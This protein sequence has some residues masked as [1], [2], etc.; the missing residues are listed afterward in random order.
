LWL[1]IVIPPAVNA[2]LSTTSA[3]SI[4][5]PSRKSS[6]TCSPHET[7]PRPAVILRV[8]LGCGGGGET[9]MSGTSTWTGSGGAAV[10][11]FRYSL[12]E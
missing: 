5:M 3:R 2:R 1:V 8:L 6:R 7:T 10:P 12:V 11:V 9:T 4:E